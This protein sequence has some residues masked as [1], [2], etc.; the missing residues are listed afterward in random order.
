MGKFAAWAVLAWFSLATAI[1]TAPVSMTH[2]GGAVPEQESFEHACTFDEPGMKNCSDTSSYLWRLSGARS[3]TTT[4]EPGREDIKTIT[5]TLIHEHTD[6]PDSRIGWT[7]D[8]GGR[9]DGTLTSGSPTAKLDIAVR[10]PLREITLTVRRLDTATCAGALRW[11][12]P[13]LKPPYKLLP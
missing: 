4:W 3:L 12:D 6:C 5:G 7:I 9:T 10:Q 11:S 8:A 2:V 13:R 1:W